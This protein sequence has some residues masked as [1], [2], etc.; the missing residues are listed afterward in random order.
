VKSIITPLIVTLL[1]LT[2]AAES[3]DAVVRTRHQLDDKPK[4]FVVVQG[5]GQ[6]AAQ[7]QQCAELLRR[8]LAAKGWRETALQ[9]ADVAVFV[10]YAPGDRTN[11]AAAER[12]LHSEMFAARAY[13]KNMNFVPVYDAMVRAAGDGGAAAALPELMKAAFEEFPGTGGQRTVSLAAQ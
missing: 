6:D 2:G 3:H 10:Q 7:Y 12:T 11:G 4:T 1:L 13:M 8:E 9:A 5:Q